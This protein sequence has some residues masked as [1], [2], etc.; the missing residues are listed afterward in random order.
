LQPTYNLQIRAAPRRGGIRLSLVSTGVR[1]FACVLLCAGAL[2]AATPAGELHPAQINSAYYRGQQ[3]KLTLDGL[4]SAK[5]TARLGPWVLGTRLKDGRPHDSRKNLYVVFPGVQYHN[6]AWPDYDLNSVINS[7]PDTEESLEWD[8]YFALVLDPSVQDDF[9]D[10]RDLVLAGQASF[11]PADLIEFDDIP[12]SNFLR[13]AMKID[14]M[15][16]LARFRH[17]N[18]MLPRV[19]ILPAGF[20]IRATVKP[21][22]VVPNT[23]YQVPSTTQVPNTEYPTAS[24]G[25]QPPSTGKQEPS[26]LLAAPKTERKAPTCHS[27]PDFRVCNYQR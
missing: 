3:V 8:V 15:A 16:G 12:A 20:A 13:A 24:A 5:S 19:A 4:M 27:G 6:D 2:S 22:E 1:R 17:K 11:Q 7:L 14:G 25:N 18:G 26:T 9:R 23:E 10:E 21:V